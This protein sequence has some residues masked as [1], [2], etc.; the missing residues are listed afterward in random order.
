MDTPERYAA[1][2]DALRTACDREGH[3]FERLELGLVVFN[4]SVGA[5]R[6]D[7]AFAGAYDDILD[8]L[9]RYREAGLQHAMIRLA[10]NASLEQTLASME[11]FAD[12]V[13]ARMD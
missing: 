12:K 4:Y 13:M 5:V 7:H 9:K 3:D 6:G 11:A 10:R 1:A 2:V 8:D